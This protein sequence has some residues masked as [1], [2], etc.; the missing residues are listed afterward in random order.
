MYCMCL[1]P[2]VLDRVQYRVE[3]QR[4]QEREKRKIEDV[5]ERERSINLYLC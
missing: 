2:K 1:Y 4:Y 3:W 5:K